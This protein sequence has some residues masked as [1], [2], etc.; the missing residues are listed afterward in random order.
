MKP[1][2]TPV[3]AAFSHVWSALIFVSFTAS[4]LLLPVFLAAS[5][6]CTPKRI[7]TGVSAEGGDYHYLYKE[8]F[9][10]K[11]DI[12]LL[13]LGG[14]QMW[15][16][17]IQVAKFQEALSK[18]LGRP[19]NVV[20]LVHPWRGVDSDH[21][22]LKDVLE[23]RKVN[24]VVVQDPPMDK[25]WPSWP[26]KY[27]EFWFSLQDWKIAEGLSAARKVSLYA[28]AVLGAPRQLLSIVRPNKIG[29]I[30][31]D[32]AKHCGTIILNRGWNDGP[33]IPTEIKCPSLS[34]D[35]LFYSTNTGG[36]SVK[37]K[38]LPDYQMHFLRRNIDLLKA[39]GIPFVFLHFPELAEPPGRQV[40][41]RMNWGKV[42]GLEIDTIGV[43]SP[44]FFQGMT[45]KQSK[46]LFYDD[47]HLNANGGSYFTRM[48]LPGVLR[49][50]EKST[51]SP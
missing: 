24:F 19:A 11:A 40:P 45:E 48:I 47:Y 8:I 38:P 35:S 5:G 42:F 4:I 6:A 50:Y 12:D 18:R 28:E 17:G 16:G 49:A 1:D 51:Q 2:R 22:L 20:A 43:P 7:Y 25:Y 33:F 9:E 44:T 36:F 21:A 3:K 26:E 29:T 27:S 31:N 23:Q 14:C 30:K 46:E 15:C 32:L 10:N 13:F 34:T 41:L 39:R 37:D